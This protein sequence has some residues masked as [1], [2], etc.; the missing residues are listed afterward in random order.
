M[1][2]ASI[3]FLGQAKVS[4]AD[5]AGV[6]RT[7]YDAGSIRDQLIKKGVLFAPQLGE[8]AFV[9]LMTGSL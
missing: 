5:V 4:R 7:V 2:K 8:I 9:V 3:A 6:E 1:I